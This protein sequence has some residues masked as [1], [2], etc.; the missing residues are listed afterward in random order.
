MRE[1]MTVHKALS[2]LKILD[3]RIESAIENLNVVVPNKHSNVKISGLS[4]AEYCDEAKK[5]FQSAVTLINRRNAIKRAV[6]RSNAITMVTVGG[7]E[8]SVAEAIDMKAKGVSY[9]SLLMEKLQ[10][11]YTKAKRAADAENGERLDNRADDYVKSL[12]SGADLK[13]MA[14][15]IK[16]VRDTFITAQTVEIVDPI[17][18]GDVATTLQAEI[19]AF[20]SDVDSAL[21]VSNALTTIEVEYETK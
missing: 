6:T 14:D 3:N 11:Q 5:S 18:A 8:Y 17:K 16:K 2:E 1:T 20:M 13:N 12:Y 9:Q 10:Y 15:E 7:K 21:S 19:D 4:V